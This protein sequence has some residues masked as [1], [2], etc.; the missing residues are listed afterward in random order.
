MKKVLLF[1]AVLTVVS[2]ASCKKKTCTYGADSY[3]DGQT[4]CADCSKLEKDVCDSAG[5]TCK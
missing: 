4:C 5:A 1:V 2:L 3:F